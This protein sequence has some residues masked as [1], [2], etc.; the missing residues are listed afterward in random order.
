MRRNIHKLICQIDDCGK[1]AK[2]YYDDFYG[3]PV[4]LCGICVKKHT[5]VYQQYTC[6]YCGKT[7]REKHSPPKIG[8][9]IVCK[10]CYWQIKNN[11]NIKKIESPKSIRCLGGKL[12]NEKYLVG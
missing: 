12:N 8:K 9:E 10:S 3:K 1:P 11:R 6:F 4:F 5:W 7:Y 2:Y